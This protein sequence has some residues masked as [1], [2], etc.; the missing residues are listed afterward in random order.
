MTAI[1]L[2][3]LRES[4][5]HLVN[6]LTT[7]Y[8]R[9]VF[10]RLIRV[11]VPASSREP[12]PWVKFRSFSS[13]PYG[14]IQLKGLVEDHGNKPRTDFISPWITPKLCMN[15]SP[16]RMWLICASLSNM[17]QFMGDSYI[18]G[19]LLVW[20]SLEERQKCAL[21][22]PFAHEAHRENV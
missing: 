22:H 5:Y 3:S 2:L 11:G 19:A 15:A 14:R 9:A 7:V 21:G 12:T 18:S 10:A 4:V 8:P 1:Q 6:T 16:S 17:Q 20:M 13:N